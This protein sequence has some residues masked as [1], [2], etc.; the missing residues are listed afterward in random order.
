MKIK[1]WIKDRHIKKSVKKVEESN[2]NNV[3]FKDGDWERSAINVR[4]NQM[5]SRAAQMSFF[6]SIF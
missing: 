3:M 2:P 1:S 6:E 4:R 5:S